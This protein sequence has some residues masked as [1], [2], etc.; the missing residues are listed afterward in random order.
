MCLCVRARTC[1]YVCMDLSLCYPFPYTDV[2]FVWSVI[3]GQ[4]R[5]KFAITA[6]RPGFDFHL[7]QMWLNVPVIDIPDSSVYD[8][9]RMLKSNVSG[10]QAQK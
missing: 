2:L 3:A 5:E 9:V 10:R 8:G 1:V 6:Y 7:E 4:A